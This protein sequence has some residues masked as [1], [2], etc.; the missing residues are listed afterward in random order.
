MMIRKQQI[1]LGV[2]AVAIV[3]GAS[4]TTA[5]GQTSEYYLHTGDQNTFIVIQNGEIVRS[6]RPPGDTDQYQ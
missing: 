1:G 6:W 5:I 2:L 3:M 4:T